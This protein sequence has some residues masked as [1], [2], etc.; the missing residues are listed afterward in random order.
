MTT[1]TIV[2]RDEWGALPWATPVYP[3]SIQARDYFFAHYNGHPPR[4]TFGVALAKEIESE[5]RAQG[6]AGPGYAFMVGQDGVIMEGRGWELVGAHCPG[7]NTRG[8]GVYG[9]VGDAQELSA[10]AKASIR[11]LRDEHAQRRA[12][13]ILTT[14][15]HGAHYPTAC[16]GVPT[17]LWVNSGMPAENVMTPA[18]PVVIPPQSPVKSS[19]VVDGQ[20]GPMTFTALQARLIRGGFSCGPAGADGQ[21]GPAST[22]ALQ[23]YLNAKLGGPDLVVDGIGF[24]QDN[25][26]YKTVAALQ[27][28]LG[29]PMDGRLSVPVSAAVKRLQDRLN[30]GNF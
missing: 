26:V 15:Y 10:Q 17:I 14:T 7:F 3:I 11:W 24:A 28:W 18:P 22:M 16:C 30:R 20:L 4:A 5:H 19:L 12:G 21:F 9:A 1:P 27:L 25:R 6:W 23:R 2:T 13:K 29:T 8:L